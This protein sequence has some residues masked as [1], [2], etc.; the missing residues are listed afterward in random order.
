MAH[1]N[2]FRL[3]ANADQMKSISHLNLH[4]KYFP[5]LRQGSTPRSAG[6]GMPKAGED[7]ERHPGEKFKLEPNLRISGVPGVHFGDC[8]LYGVQWMSHCSPFCS[9]TV[10]LD[11]WSIVVVG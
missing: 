4:T 5:G 9:D 3:V 1:T 10:G 6:Q 7:G 2:Q 8:G 11:L